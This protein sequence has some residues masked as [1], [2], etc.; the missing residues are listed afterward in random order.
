MA[1]TRQFIANS[2]NKSF[3]LTDLSSPSIQFLVTIIAINKM[4]ITIGKLSTA[5]KML[6]LLALAAMPESTVSDAEKP[7]DPKI[8]RMTKSPVS[9]N[10]FFKR[11][12]NKTKPANESSRESKK[13]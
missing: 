9:A 10:G 3:V 7:N 4:E 8:N 2:V 12:M 13:L 1:A 11:V 6:L 5:I